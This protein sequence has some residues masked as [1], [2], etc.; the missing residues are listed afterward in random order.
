[1]ENKAP[2]LLP[3]L[4]KEQQIELLAGCEESFNPDNLLPHEAMKDRHSRWMEPEE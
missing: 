3:L 2:E 4:T 1:M